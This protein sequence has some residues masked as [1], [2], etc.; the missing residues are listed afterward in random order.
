MAD[1]LK[2]LQVLLKAEGGYV[3]DPAD[4]GGETNYG[5]TKKSYPME[6][7]KHITM[8]RVKDIYKRDYWDKV[9]GDEIKDQ[10]SAL[11]IF[12]FA[13]NAGVNTAVK[14]LQSILGLTQDG[15][16]GPMSIFS[17]NAADP[18]L[19]LRE[20]ASGRVSFYEMIVKRKPINQ[21]FLKIWL[22]R[23]ADILK[24]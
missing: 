22:K 1:F 21:K 4:A 20:Y 7:I 24:E 2:A 17:L 16:L 10:K 15:I 9:K 3:N 6:D 13:V 8:D 18:V 5:I 14:L 19:F 12:D 23:I 11:M